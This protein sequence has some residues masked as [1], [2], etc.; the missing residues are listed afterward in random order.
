MRNNEYAGKRDIG[1]STLPKSPE[2]SAIFK[3]VFILVKLLFESEIKFEVIE[4][5]DS[6]IYAF[7]N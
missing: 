6:W 4:P 5:W 7:G 2:F 3:E 1:N